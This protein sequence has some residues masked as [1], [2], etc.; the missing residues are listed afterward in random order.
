MRRREFIAG[1]GSAAAWPVLAWAQQ[2]PIPTIGFLVP[3]TN[4]PALLAAL[5]AA[6]SKRLM[7]VGYVVGQNVKVEY[8]LADEE[9]RE[10]HREF[11]ADLVRRQVS[12][13]LAN[14]TGPALA[15]KGAT[16]T[17]PIV[18]YNTADPVKLGLVASVNRPEANVTGV[19]FGFDDVVAKRVELLCQLVPTATKIAYLSGGPFWLAFRVERPIVIA[20]ADRLNRQLIEVECPS[21]DALGES[22]ATMIDRGAGAVIISAIPLFNNNAD[23]VVRLAERYKIPAMC[24][25]RGHVLR[26]GLMSYTPDSQEGFKIAVGLVGEILKGA[27]PADLPVRN[28]NKFDFVI[29]LKTA[30]HLGLEIPPHLLVFANELIN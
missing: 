26:G 30:K 23:E 28:P 18:F 8:R 4:S 1:L 14:A 3:G 12:V 20:A 24:P 25:S 5:S 21:K 17:I 2:R 19:G 9:I 27:K 10:R 29:N 7:E 16:S 13:I 22:F 15:A 11:A 6:L